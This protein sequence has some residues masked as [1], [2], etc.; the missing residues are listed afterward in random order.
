M[1]NGR[2]CPFCGSDNLRRF[3]VVTKNIAFVPKR[4]CVV[5]CRA[6]ITAWQ[7]PTDVKE[8][9]I[10]AY[11]GEQY[12]LQQERTYF[13]A[14]LKEQ[15][16]KLGLRFVEHARHEKRGTILD[17]GAGDG[18]FAK[19]ANSC[20]WEAVGVDLSFA[21]DLVVQGTIDD[22]D[23]RFDVVTLWDVIEHVEHP[24]HLIKKAFNK[25]TKNGLII[26]ETGNY[27][28]IDRIMNDVNWWGFQPD[29]R[30]FFAPTA[31]E[32]LLSDAGFMRFE[33]SA[34]ILRP[35]CTQ[36]HDYSGPSRSTFLKE[37]IKRPHKIRMHIRQ[38][39]DLQASAD[40]HPHLSEI[41]IF[42]VA[43]SKE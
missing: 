1:R 15:R 37:I 9:E 42:A 8:S 2:R 35:N 33:Y 41:G 43:A 40:R 18:T 14:E 20:G 19:I 22:V 6:C 13:D 5:E 30:W 16:S 39:S 27:L 34:H 11:Y 10:R 29:H 17:V 12:F 36:A 31:L 38:F 21:S 24:D 25:L 3:S 32:K 7:W 23:G 4:I 28:G 26:I